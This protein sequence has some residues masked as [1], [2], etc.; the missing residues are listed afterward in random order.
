MFQLVEEK[1][2][3]RPSPDNE[4]HTICEREGYVSSNV[5]GAGRALVKLGVNRLDKG[6]QKTV[7]GY[8]WVLGQ[9]YSSKDSPV[10]QSTSPKQKLN[11][12][13]EKI[14]T[15]AQMA[16][17]MA[18]SKAASVIVQNAAQCSPSSNS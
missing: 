11:D 7:L 12:K 17:D 3:Y 8:E 4:E 14:K 10:V 9:M 5:L 18:K 16:K 1:C 2:V 13:A 6:M 15:T